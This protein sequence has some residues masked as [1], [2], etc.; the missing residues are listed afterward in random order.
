M[1]EECGDGEERMTIDKSKPKDMWVSVQWKTKSY[2]LMDLHVSDT[3]GDVTRGT[4]T[5]KDSDE[6]DDE[7]NRR[8]F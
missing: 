3:L 1:S 2:K 5:P 7:V 8:E 4:G 6:G